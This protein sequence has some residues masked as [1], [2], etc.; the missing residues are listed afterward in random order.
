LEVVG[1]N[2]DDGIEFQVVDIN[3]RRVD[4]DEFQMELR[5]RILF[6]VLNS[7]FEDVRVAL[8]V[9]E[10]DGVTAARGSEQLEQ[11]CHV[12]ANLVG[13]V[14]SVFLEC[15]RVK[16]HV[17]ETNLSAIHRR[18]FDTGGAESDGH[19]VKNFFEGVE[20]T[21]DN[22]SLNRSNTEQNVI[23]SHLRFR[24]VFF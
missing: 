7:D 22:G 3:T 17:N 5:R 2:A 11:I 23:G 8:E 6:K 18:N 19:I 24:N 13:V 16:F 1:R 14:A 12:H 4:L 15:F 9:T 20:E 10:H 21:F